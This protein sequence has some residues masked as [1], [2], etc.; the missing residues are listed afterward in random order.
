[1]WRRGGSAVNMDAVYTMQEI[2]IGSFIVDAET[3]YEA[4]AHV[5]EFSEEIT[6]LID[7]GI[8]SWSIQQP[9]H[10]VGL[11]RIDLMGNRSSTDVYAFIVLAPKKPEFAFMRTPGPST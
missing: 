11:D 3:V 4:V 7:T 1:M 8:S 9:C 10:Y 6:N 5:G 2:G